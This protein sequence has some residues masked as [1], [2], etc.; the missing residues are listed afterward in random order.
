M[1]THIYTNNDI[2][3][4]TGLTGGLIVLFLFYCTSTFFSYFFDIHSVCYYWLTFTILTGIWEYTYVTHR[5]YVIEK[6]QYLLDNKLHVWFMKHDID[7]I[8]PWNTAIIF[9]SEYGAYADKEYM[10]NK[11]KWSIAIEGSHALL[12]AV[13]A[14]L[15]LYFNINNNFKNFYIT[16]AISMG[17]QLMNSILYMVEY[18]IQ[19]KTQSSVNYNTDQFPCGKYLVKRPF[20]YINIFWTIMPIYVL[21]YYLLYDNTLLY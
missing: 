6:S 15:A 21:S 19:I 20:I 13:F 8:L 17:T 12:C 3:K 4:V 5:N 10:I 2:F 9:Y 18:F 16:L 14:F 7:I 1:T 11:D